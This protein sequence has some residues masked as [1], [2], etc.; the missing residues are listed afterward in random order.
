[1]INLIDLMKKDVKEGMIRYKPEDQFIMDCLKSQFQSDAN[2]RMYPGLNWDYLIDTASRNKVVPLLHLALKSFQIPKAL[3]ENSYRNAIHSLKLTGELTRIL[4]FLAVPSIPFK[5]PMLA[6]Q[7]YG[8]VSHRQFDDLDLLIREKDFHS[9]KSD[10][11]KNGYIIVDKLRRDQETAFLKSHHHCQFLNPITGVGLEVH[12][13]IS[14]KIYSFRLDVSELFQRAT[15]VKLFGQEILTLSREDSI[16]VLS[17]HG[18]RHYW[19][20]LGWI[21]D[22]AKL[23]QSEVDWAKVMKIAKSVGSK[24]SILLAISLARDILDLK[25][26]DLPPSGAHK[27]ITILSREVQARLFTS[28][29]LND[30]EIEQFY[31]RCR[32]RRMDRFRYYVYRATVPTKDDWAYIDLPGYLFPFYHLI[33]PIRLINK[34]R[35]NV[36]KWLRW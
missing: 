23:C 4:G 19:S 7:A 15:Y 10:L 27:E 18:T 17:E 29:P 12:W 8:N 6:A 2:L 5:G 33:R 30:P 36:I 9:A 28:Y 22:I 3:K 31:I 26:P 24:R 32:E 1:M 25:T 34:H 16:I 14:P 11:L 20:R 35:Y 13:Q 21:C